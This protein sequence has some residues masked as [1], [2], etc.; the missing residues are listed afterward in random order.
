MTFNNSMVYVVDDDPEICKSFCWLFESVNLKVAA[1]KNA[2][3]FL[4]NYNDNQYGCLII[5][6]RMPRMSGIELLEYLNTI[7]NQ[8]SV[9]VITG[10]GDI[11]MAVR[12]MKAGAFDFI[13]KPVNHQEL[14]ELTQKCLNKTQTQELSQLETDIHK[15]IKS[16][17]PREKQVMDLVVDGKLNKQIAYELNISISTVEAH[18]A[19]IMKKME[20]KTLAALVKINLLHTTLIKSPGPVQQ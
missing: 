20:T 10:Y 16:L 15:R 18:R 12:A 8:L 7:K 6:V 4:D 5:D 11:P 2:K 9:V 19:K 17:T 3:D 1:Y 13:L 14:L